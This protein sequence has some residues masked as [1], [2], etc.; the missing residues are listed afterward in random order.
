MKID[1]KI[2]DQVVQFGYP[3]HLILNYLQNNQL[4]YATTSYLLFYL[5]KKGEGRSINNKND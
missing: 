4:N 1:D 5:L 2:V 3:K